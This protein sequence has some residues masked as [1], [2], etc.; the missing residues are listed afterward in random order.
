LLIKLIIDEAGSD[1]AE[2]IW[3]Q[4]DVLVAARLLY[5]EGRAALAAARGTS[6]TS[7]ARWEF[8]YFPVSEPPRVP[9]A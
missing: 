8:R 5:V 4:P 3:D 1:A 6:D 2:V 9:T 7:R